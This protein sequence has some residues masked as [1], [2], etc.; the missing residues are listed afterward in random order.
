MYNKKNI[1]LATLT[2]TT[3]DVCVTVCVHVKL[4]HFSCNTYLRS[5]ANFWSSTFC[6]CNCSSSSMALRSWR[7]TRGAVSP[8]G[9][10]RE[11]LMYIMKR[12][13]DSMTRPSS[14]QRFMTGLEPIH[15]KYKQ[16]KH[17]ILLHFYIDQIIFLEKKKQK[18]NPLL[19][20]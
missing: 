12:T 18:N 9:D 6:E 8:G 11:E 10:V 4:M 5:T 14:C 16:I 19:M 13:H 3:V 7:S 17:K 20:L 1:V 15:D 2:C